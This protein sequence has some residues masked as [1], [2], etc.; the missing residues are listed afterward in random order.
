MEQ[1]LF[2]LINDIDF[3]LNIKIAQFN[4]GYNNSILKMKRLP[5]LLKSPLHKS[6]FV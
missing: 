4:S 1:L 5:G 6:P 3:P 2:H